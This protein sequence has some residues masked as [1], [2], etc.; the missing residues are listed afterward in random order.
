MCALHTAPYFTVKSSCLPLF[1]DLLISHQ[2]LHRKYK[3]ARILQS[4]IQNSQSIC[5]TLAGKNLEGI[6]RSD[7]DTKFYF[8][9]TRLNSE[10]T[11][12]ELNCFF[13]LTRPRHAVSLTRRRRLACRGHPLASYA[14]G[15]ESSPTQIAVPLPLPAAR[16]LRRQRGG[17]E[18]VQ[19]R[20][21]GVA[22][23]GAG[24]QQQR[25]N[26]TQQYRRQLPNWP[27]GQLG[28]R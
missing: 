19:H 6:R 28:R 25:G 3:L 20:K 22:G 27:R 26:T 15:T 12:N 23:R 13:S 21:S 1:R 24:R 17:R 5:A 7:F 2:I 8:S 14:M 16:Q 10:R 11:T 9:H 18:Q 4:E